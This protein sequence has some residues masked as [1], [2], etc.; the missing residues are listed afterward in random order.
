M[1]SRLIPAARSLIREKNGRGRFVAVAHDVMRLSAETSFM[2]RM[3][4]LSAIRKTH[5]GAR[6]MFLSDLREMGRRPFPEMH[7]TVQLLTHFAP[8]PKQ[9]AAAKDPPFQE[10]VIPE[11]LR[12]Y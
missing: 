7:L 11:R 2:Y 4:S 3:T 9:R 1:A 12:A 5:W 8:Q 6:R 10:V